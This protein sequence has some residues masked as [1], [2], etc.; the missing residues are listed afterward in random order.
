MLKNKLEPYAE[1]VIEEYQLGFRPGYQQL[2][3][4]PQCNRR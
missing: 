3:R 1:K 4:F 2:I